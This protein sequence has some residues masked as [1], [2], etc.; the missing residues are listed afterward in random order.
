[1]LPANAAR[2]L[3]MLAPDARVLD[4]G[5][6]A[7]PFNRATHVL[8]FMPYES[9]GQ[10]GSYG[11]GPER[12]T[13]ETWA[14]RDMCDR[15][16]WPYPDG[17]FDFARCVTTLEDVR[18]PVW[19]CQEMQRVARAGYVEVPTVLAEL[20]Y[21]PN[22]EGG[23]VGHDHYRWLCEI[24]DGEL[25]FLLKPG[26]LHLDWRLRVRPRWAQ[27]MTLADHLQFLF[28]E[29]ELPVRERLVLGPEFPREELAA[30]VSERFRP[31]PLEIRAKAARE[32]VRH[33]GGRMRQPARRTVERGLDRLAGR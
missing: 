4:V 29:G 24:V 28:W 21:H 15:E 7:A 13:A 10:M 25:V 9:R 5:G 2:I 17:H 18:D 32:T 23:F 33:L 11:P 12:F 3:E 27:T 1:M 31:S 14:R 8:D 19:V 30:R 26:S 22:G 6:W 16:P 20:I